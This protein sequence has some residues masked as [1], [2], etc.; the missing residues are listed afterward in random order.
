[1]D[2]ITPLRGPKAG[3]TE[4]VITGKNLVA[5]DPTI[6]DQEKPVVKIGSLECEVV[7]GW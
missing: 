4:I 5:F 1:M 6:A 2:D 3:G 7:A